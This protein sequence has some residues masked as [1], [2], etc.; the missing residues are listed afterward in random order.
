M[1]CIA[2]LLSEGFAVDSRYLESSISKIPEKK[3]NGAA[4]L[5][6]AFNRWQLAGQTRL[7]AGLGSP[8][9]FHLS[10]SHS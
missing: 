7:R 1:A 9:V 5:A 10:I 2:V 8:L 3:G 6:L 4:V